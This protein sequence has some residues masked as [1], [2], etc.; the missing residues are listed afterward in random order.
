MKE[1]KDDEGRPWRLALTCA[2]AARVKDLVRVEV[3]EEVPQPDGSVKHETRS[4]PFDLIDTA[5]IGRTLEVLRGQYGTIGETLYAILIK[6]VDEKKLS[7]EQFLDG[8][9][10]DALDAAAKALEAELVD[11]FPL[12]LRKMVGLL[13]AKMDELTTELLGRS[14][15]GLQAATPE[16]LLAQS[17]MPS[18]KPPE[19]SASIP[20]DGPTDSSSPPAPP[21]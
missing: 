19:S 21:G 10:G 7:K 12:R 20:A 16:T 13:V 14:E 4:V 6:Q 18:G 17:G 9:R 8:L 5:N 11:F 3:A 1:F 2:S 15:A